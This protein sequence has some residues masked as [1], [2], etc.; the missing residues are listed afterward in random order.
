MTK[1]A[2]A[3]SGKREAKFVWNLLVLP[4]TTYTHIGYSALPL[5]ASA[6]PPRA[7]AR[8]Y[9]TTVRSNNPLLMHELHKFSRSHQLTRTVP[10]QVKTL[11]YSGSTTTSLSSVKVKQCSQAK[12]SL[13]GPRALARA[14]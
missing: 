11:K 9:R 14:A 8:I 6:P 5:A 12:F 3:T 7:P 4:Y 13:Y 10:L 1:L 2:L